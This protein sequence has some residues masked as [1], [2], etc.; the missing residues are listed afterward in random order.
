MATATRGIVH[1]EN[2]IGHDRD[3]RTTCK[4]LMNTGA[5]PCGEYA[6][7]AFQAATRRPGHNSPERGRRG[8]S[9]MTRRA[10][11]CRDRPPAL[12]AACVYGRDGPRPFLRPRL[13]FG[14]VHGAGTWL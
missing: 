10:Q 4:R 7:A 9:R 14:P 6:G 2:R 5:V 3:F 11:L 1:H 12:R 8:D 13:T